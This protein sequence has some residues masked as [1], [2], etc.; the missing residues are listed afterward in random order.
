MSFGPKVMFW[1]NHMH[2]YLRRF[3][4]CVSIIIVECCSG[5]KKKKKKKSRI[6][7]VQY[8]FNRKVNSSIPYQLISYL[9]SFTHLNK[10]GHAQNL[11]Y[12]LYFSEFHEYSYGL[13]RT[14][15]VFQLLLPLW[16][17]LLLSGIPTAPFNS[18][19]LDQ[20]P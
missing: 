6:F 8:K 10:T 20:S 1:E 14:L 16:I 7:F 12:Q 2:K 4:I 19:T 5:F 13:K 9:L 11:S 3:V 17:I 18:W 15:K